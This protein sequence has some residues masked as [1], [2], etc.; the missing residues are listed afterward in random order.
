MPIK[1]ENRELYPKNWKQISE[2]IIFE[3]AKN[4]CEVCGVNNHAVGYRDEN[5]KF[6]PD[7]GNP[8]LEDYGEG[9]DS[10][11]NEFIS[12][13]KAKEHAEFNTYTCELGRKYIVI[14]LTTAHLDHD[15]TNNDYSNLKAMCQKCHN[16]YDKKHRKQTRMETKNKGQL[17]LSI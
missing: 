14:V 11:T 10:S 3:R 16:N 12:Y 5:A 15:P 7:S 17:K 6:I 13:K 9:I 8:I 1:P 2:Y 4:K